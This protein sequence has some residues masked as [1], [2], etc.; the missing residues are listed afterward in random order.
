MK[1]IGHRGAKGLAP[2]NTI[3][4]F[5]KALEHHV[6]EIELDVRLTADSKVVVIHNP[7]LVDANGSTLKVSEHTLAELQAHK[8]DLPTLAE[9]ISAINRQVPI[10]IEVKPG[11]SS[12]PVAKIVKAFLE[13]GW[14]AR[15][16]CFGS[17]DQSILLE[18][19]AQLPDIETMVIEFWSGIRATKRARQLGTRRIGMLEYGLWPGFIAAMKHSG[20]EL[21]GA[22][23]GTA[24]KKRLFSKLGM[25]GHVDNPAKARKWAKYGLAGVITDY[26]DRYEAW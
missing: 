3:A 7:E 25:A 17:R 2:E 18:L 1:I 9:A 19:H 23:P 11:V 6:D 16:F 4:S 26:P 22:P 24:Q 20:Y 12:K 14:Q 15:D 13:K 8:P 10:I 21:Y 5:K